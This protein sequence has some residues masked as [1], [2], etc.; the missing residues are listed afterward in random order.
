MTMQSSLPSPAPVP[1][2]A[3]DEALRTGPVATASRT[4]RS[5]WLLGALKWLLL[6]LLL[7]GLAGPLLF[8]LGQ[9]VLTPDGNRAGT[10]P[11]VTLFS[12]INFLPMLGR[13]LWVSAIT[14]LVTVPLAYLFAYALQRSCI[15]FKGLWRGIGLLPLLAPSLDSI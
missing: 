11:F 13:S 9:A 12:N 4:D 14:A 1:T 6:A 7:V 5:Q 15:P 3:I 2:P 10:Q 8:I